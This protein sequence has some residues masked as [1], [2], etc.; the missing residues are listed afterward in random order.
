MTI[1]T[2]LTAETKVQISSLM[3]TNQW[4]LNLTNGFWILL[5]KRIWTLY[6]IHQIEKWPYIYTEAQERKRKWKQKRGHVNIYNVVSCK[7]YGRALAKHS[8]LICHTH[9]QCNLILLPPY[10]LWTLW[11]CT[12]I[13]SIKAWGNYKFLSLSLSLYIYI[14]VCVCV[15]VCVCIEKINN[16]N[17]NAYIWTDCMDIKGILLVKWLKEA[18]KG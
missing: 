17:N 15:C 8:P 4:L 18:R 14:Y 2:H 9:L 6:I 16:N 5:E 7:F 1:P 12:Q 10:P 3:R 13:L 11:V